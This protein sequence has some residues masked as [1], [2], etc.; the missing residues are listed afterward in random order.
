MGLRPCRRHDRHVLASLI[1]RRVKGVNSLSVTKCL[2]L[3]KYEAFDKGKEATPEG[4]LPTDHI[5]AERQVMIHATDDE[6]R[7]SCKI[8]DATLLLCSILCLFGQQPV[9]S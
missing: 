2:I 3:M 6:I 9:K 1:A 7:R 8:Q 4:V 5:A